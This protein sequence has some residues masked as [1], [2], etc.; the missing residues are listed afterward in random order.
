MLES[1]PCCLFLIC[2][3]QKER[4]R[5]RKTTVPRTVS[6]ICVYTSIGISGKQTGGS[7][8]SVAITVMEAQYLVSLQLP[9]KK[10]AREAALSGREQSSLQNLLS[11]KCLSS[12]TNGTQHC[13]N[14]CQTSAPKMKCHTTHRMLHLKSHILKL[15]NN[16]T[17]KE[18][19]P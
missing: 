4:K 19:C 17:H 3:V 7:H 13:I 9:I 15:S 14:H 12:R 5:K 18:R 1:S 6:P 8:Y 2:R 16:K 11:A 10:A